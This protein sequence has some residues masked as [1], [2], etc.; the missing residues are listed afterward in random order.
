MFPGQLAV[1]TRRAL[2][3]TAVRRDVSCALGPGD[4]S[5]YLYAAHLQALRRAVV[6]A[7]R[8]PAS[9]RLA[10]VRLTSALAPAVAQPCRYL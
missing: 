3:V 4:A 5:P 9:P 2:I 8:K 1:D 7:S 10:R 6:T